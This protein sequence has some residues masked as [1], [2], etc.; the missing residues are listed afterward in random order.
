M[1]CKSADMLG[2][3]PTTGVGEGRRH[4]RA[5]VSR[6][7]IY[8]QDEHPTTSV[9]LKL[10]AAFPQ[11]TAMPL[12]CEHCLWTKLRLALMAPPLLYRTTSVQNRNEKYQNILTAPK[13]A[14]KH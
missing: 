2:T 14:V 12:R 13:S 10:L 8:F 7:Y 5:A 1:E 11:C 9:I 4:N 6:D 3:Q